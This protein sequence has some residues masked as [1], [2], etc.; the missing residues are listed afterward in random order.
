MGQG[1]L[2]RS[3]PLLASVEDPSARYAELMAER[4][5]LYQQVADLVVKTNQRTARYV[6]KEIM[7]RLATL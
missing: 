1:N 5:P 7:K 3:R 6:V 4:E 2:N